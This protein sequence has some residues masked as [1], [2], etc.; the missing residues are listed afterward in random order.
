MLFQYYNGSVAM[1]AL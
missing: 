1:L